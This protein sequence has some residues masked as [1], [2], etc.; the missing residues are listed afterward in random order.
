VGFEYPARGK[1]NTQEQE[2]SMKRFFTLLTV[3]V[4][5]V[6]STLMAAQAG[7]AEQEVLAVQN[8][9]N[10]ALVKSDVATLDKLI[11]ADTNV[12]SANG[13]AST[14]ADVLDGFRSGKI[15]Y[16]Q[17][18]NLDAKVR[19]YGNVAVV[20]STQNIMGQALGNDMSGRYRVTQM[21]VKRDGRWR[22]VQR[23]VTR[24]VPPKS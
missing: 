3:A 8:R 7:K 18:E 5:L 15:K 1:L 23:Q 4:L 17:I 22:A 13:Q 12:V 10:E 24:I 21:F 9:L 2:A 6:A 16:Q 11:G 20:N 14:K 19:I